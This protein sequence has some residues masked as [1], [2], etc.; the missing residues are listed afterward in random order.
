[1]N[2]CQRPRPGVWLLLAATLTVALAFGTSAADD[3]P[4]S[5]T[6]LASAAEQS[7]AAHEFRRAGELLERAIQ[8]GAKTPAAPYESACSYSRAGDRDRA[9]AMLDRAVAMGFRNV[10]E[11]TANNDLAALHGDARWTPLVSRVTDAQAAFRKTHANPTSARFETSDIARFWQAYE[12]LS[13]AADPAT[14]LETEY[15]DIGSAGLQEFIPGRITSGQKLHQVIQQHPKYF[16][17]I[18]KATQTLATLE[19]EVRQELRNLQNLYA[20]ATFPDIYYVIGAMSSGG[21]STPSGL[22]MGVELFGRGPGVPMDEMTDWHRAVIQDT[23]ALASITAHELIHF[24]Q[25]GGAHTLLER[26]FM[27][28]SA[29]FIASLISKGNFNKHIYKYGYAHEA[30]L[31]RQF[32][33]EMAGSDV[34]NWLYGGTPRGDRPADLGYFVGFR[35][36]QAYYERATD[37]RQAIR[38]IIVPPAGVEKLLADSHYGQRFS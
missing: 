11:L 34:S 6:A 16:A 12:K 2:A 27:E 22:V 35:I 8:R 1:M 7:Y 38:D 36:A 13:S 37:K 25:R 24:Q 18:R 14:L 20:D 17:A 9:F 28:G 32:R 26:A 33:G 31:W 23:A 21:T 3:E 15:L 4:R 19:P 5:A 30:A 29:D 10:D